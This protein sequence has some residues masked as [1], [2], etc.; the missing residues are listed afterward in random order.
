MIDKRQHRMSWLEET[1]VNVRALF[2][3][4]GDT[5]ESIWLFAEECPSPFMQGHRVFA[6]VSR[7]EGKGLSIAVIDQF[8]GCLPL[9]VTYNTLIRGALQAPMI[10]TIALDSNVV[11]SLSRYLDPDS[12]LTAGE[13]HAIQ[14]FLH[15]L[16]HGGFDYNP[17]FYFFESIGEA[18]DTETAE[19]AWRTSQ[20]MLHFHT[21]DE[22]HFL[23]TGEVR[24]DPK[25]LAPYQEQYSA[26]TIPEIAARQTGKML[27]DTPVIP[28][29]LLNSMRALLLKMALIHRTSRASFWDK[30]ILLREFSTNVLKT[31][32][33]RER[34]L[35]LYYFSGEMDRFIPL[36]RTSSFR[37]FQ[38]SLRAAAWD[39]LLLRMPET[40]LARD[41]ANGT[42]VIYVCTGDR[43]LQKVAQCNKI[44]YVYAM[45]PHGLPVPQFASDLTDLIPIVGGDVL[46][47]IVKSDREWQREGVL[48]L[49][50][51]RSDCP[52]G[53][54]LKRLVRELEAEVER[55]CEP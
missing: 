19:A 51:P 4:T 8:D 5:G 18:P 55:F 25:Q 12:R 15:F 10:P 45:P 46:D 50:N 44:L 33:G 7:P 1:L 41:V 3:L 31:R 11:S 54:D 43:A 20:T 39:L 21:M 37:K 40:F 29:N 6:D 23:A 36:Q 14:E 49:G 53:D 52:S 16:I 35:A 22:P 2:S 26:E 34:T 27:S 48:K 28:I 13:R 32:F 9:E 47:K 17:V 42:P 30:Y 38:R 24:P